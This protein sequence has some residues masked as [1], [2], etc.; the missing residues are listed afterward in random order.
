M[1]LCEISDDLGQ[2]IGRD[3][4]DH[5]DA[6]TTRK[7]VPRRAREVSEFIDRAQDVADAPGEVFPEPRQRDLPRASLQEHAAERVLE[8]LDLHRQ[9]RLRD[10]TCFRRAAE[11]AMPGQRI[12]IAQLPKRDVYHQ[13]ILLQRSLKST[14]PDEM[15]C[16]D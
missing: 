16:V 1:R 5:A 12:E 10:R 4:W 7:P 2:Q 13:K 14:L 9:G 6:Q 15:R 11:M 8:S 3:R